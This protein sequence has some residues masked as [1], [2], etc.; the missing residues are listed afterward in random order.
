MNFI[1]DLL[2][3]LICVVNLALGCYIFVKRYNTSYALSYFIMSLGISTWAVSNYLFNKPYGLEASYIFDVFANLG[4]LLLVQGLYFFSRRF[5]PIDGKEFKSNLFDK[6]NLLLGVAFSIVVFIPGLIDKEVYFNTE[7]V[8]SLEIGPLKTPFYILILFNIFAS[9]YVMITSAKQ[10][11]GLA[12]YQKKIM[13][14]S[15]V[16]SAFAGVLF[17]LLLP[18]AGIYNYTILG[19]AFLATL[20]FSSFY[21]MVSYRLA[22]LRMIFSYTL[23]KLILIAFLVG[24]FNYV[25]YAE[26]ELFPERSYAIGLILTVVVGLIYFYVYDRLKFR[27]RSRYLLA[28]NFE[29]YLDVFEQESI[30]INSEK[31]IIALYTNILQEVVRIKDIKVLIKKDEDENKII[32]YLDSHLHKFKGEIFILDEEEKKFVD[33]V[34]TDSKLVDILKDSAIN[35]GYRNIFRMKYLDNALGYVLMSQKLDNQAFSNYEINFIENLTNKFATFLYKIELYEQK[36]HLNKVLNARIDKATATLR[37]QKEQL[38]EKYQFEKDMMGIMGH[39][40]RTPMTVAKGMAELVL[41]KAKLNDLNPTYVEE[42]M[43]KVYTSIIKEADLI[44]TMLSTSHLDNN[45]LN[46]QIG[47]VDLRDSVEYA[48]SAF[49]KDAEDKGL[50]FI[51]E[52]PDFEIPVLMLDAG[53]A[54]EIVNNLVSNA[55]KYTKAGHVK[56]YFTKTEEELIFHVEDT[57]IGIPKDEIKNLGQKFHRINQHLDKEKQ[58]VRSG[59]TGLGLYVVKGLL[60]AFGGKL[61]VVSELGKG[62]TFSAVFPLTSKFKDNLPFDIN[63]HTKSD[64]FENMGLKKKVKK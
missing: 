8:K 4:A 57:G 18:F 13:L 34:L 39:E 30:R 44:Q 63:F 33:G 16:F 54:Q 23:E 7:G 59:G 21:S 3:I 52:D 46:L 45:R 28:P 61:D 50:R 19:P 27:S 2:L 32:K 36:V 9:I 12:K 60:E 42:K 37:K 55:V 26:H 62:S 49:R 15:F 17:N 47:P 48:A 31:D 20:T 1:V 35:F 53:R 64:M 5:P 43:R 22:D 10:L 29:Y 24:G 58:I 6:I 56:M 14:S 40:L 41:G 38:Q 51:L 11:N 25:F